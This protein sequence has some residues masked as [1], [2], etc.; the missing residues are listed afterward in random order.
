MTA[1]AP[2]AELA[3]LIRRRAKRCRAAAA[4]ILLAGLAGAGVIYWLGSRTAAESINPS[5]LGLHRAE[6]RQMG[7]L[8]GRQGQLYDDLTESLKQPGTQ[9]V[10]VFAAAALIAGGCFYFSR[11]LDDEATEIA[12]ADTQA[13]GPPVKQS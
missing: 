6:R 4:G 2:S 3:P 11:V 9:A 13:G 1:P 10:L 5:L 7:L 8:Y 12:G